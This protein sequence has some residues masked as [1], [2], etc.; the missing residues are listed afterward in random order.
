VSAAHTPGPWHASKL[1][2]RSEFNIFMPGYC[3]AGASVH[4]CGNATG[5]MGSLVVEANARLIAAAPTLLEAL[6]Y[7]ATGGES[8]DDCVRKARAAIAAAKGRP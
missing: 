4:H 8:W 7:I 3:S 5:C 1:E 2:D 6:E